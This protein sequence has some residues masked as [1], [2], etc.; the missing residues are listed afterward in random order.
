MGFVPAYYV[1][2]FSLLKVPFLTFINLWFSRDSAVGRWSG[3][4]NKQNSL[5]KLKAMTKITAN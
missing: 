1:I 4:L 5:I 3:S 2:W